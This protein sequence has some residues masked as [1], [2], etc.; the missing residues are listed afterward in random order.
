[1]TRIIPLLLAAA[2]A[3]PTL[4]FAAG[5][6]QTGDRCEQHGNFLMKADKDKD[7]TIDRAEARAMQEK[8]FDAMDTNHDGKLS[9]EEIAACKNK[10]NAG[11]DMGS[12]GFSK[13]DKDS[14]GTLTRD[15][16]NALPRVSKHFDE[17]D[18]DKDG[19]LDRDEIHNFMKNHAGK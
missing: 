13:A 15:E 17:I 14:D 16:A 12:K 1:M 6:A 5:D 7:G 4:T 11:H 19:T 9:K 8:R 2:L 3:I 18:T 10:R